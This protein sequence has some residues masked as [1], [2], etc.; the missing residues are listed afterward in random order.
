MD[1]FENENDDRIKLKDS[2]NITLQKVFIDEIGI[3]KQMI[4]INQ[5]IHIT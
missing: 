5:E 4:L 2:E 1:K 3:T